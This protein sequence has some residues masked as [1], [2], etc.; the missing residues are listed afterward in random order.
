MKK[1][2]FYLIVIGVFFLSFNIWGQT[3]NSDKDMEYVP[4]YIV[5]TEN[6]TIKGEILYKHFSQLQKEVTFRKTASDAPKTYLPA[7]IVGYGHSLDA[8]SWTSTANTLLQTKNKKGQFVQAEIIGGVSY[9]RYYKKN[10]EQPQVYDSEIF[11]IKPNEDAVSTDRLVIGF[12]K[13]F[14]NYLSDNKEIAKKIANKEP[15]YK[16]SSVKDIIKEYNAWYKQ[17]HPDFTIVSLKK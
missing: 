6:D 2:H 9:Y 15:G 12:K 13:V 17:Q 3:F 4:G 14:S 10:K 8:L 7:D 11:V 1:L 16:M 5:N